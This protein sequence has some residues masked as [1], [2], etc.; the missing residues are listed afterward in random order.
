MDANKAS[1]VEKKYLR[2]PEIERAAREVVGERP[3]SAELAGDPLAH[4]FPDDLSF[5]NMLPSMAQ[6]GA[7]QVPGQP[8]P[9]MELAGVFD[10]PLVYKT[11]FYTLTELGAKPEQARGIVRIFRFYPPDDYV[12]LDE[13]LKDA[14]L[15]PGV[16]RLVVKSWR[17]AS[18]DSDAATDT[19]DSGVPSAADSE[20]NMNAVRKKL[21]KL[22]QELGIASP[23]DLNAAVED[24]EKLRLMYEVEEAKE[25]LKQLKTGGRPKDDSDENDTMEVLININGIPVKKIIKTKDYHIWEPVIMKPKNTGDDGE[26]MIEVTLDING[27]RAKKKIKIDDIGKWEKYI[28][29]DTEPGGDEYTTV[30]LNFGGQPI[31]RKIK[32]SML[33]LYA[34]YIVKPGDRERG[35][36]SAEI[37]ELRKQVAQ[38]ADMLA[39]ERNEKARER[40]AEKYERQF[41]ALRQEISQL[42]SKPQTYDDPVQKRIDEMEKQFQAQ[43][44]D[45]YMQQM[46]NLQQ[47][48]ES[49][50]QEMQRLRDQL[51]NISNF[52]YAIEQQQRFAQLARKQGYVDAREARRLSEE[53]IEMEDRLNMVKRKDEAQARVL[54]IAA[55][56]LEK[57]GDLK[58]AFINNGG[59]DLLIDMLK[60]ITTSRE[61]QEAAMYRPTVE[62][63]RRKAEQLVR[64]EAEQYTPQ[65]EQPVEQPAPS[66]STEEGK[67]KEK[68]RDGESGLEVA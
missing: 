12:A 44:D 15:S 4:E 47:T 48:L 54:N 31:E 68:P 17:L 49:Y 29:R 56:K 38:M 62:D 41:E 33:H 42:R 64:A 7:Q 61:E 27:V 16:R 57:T 28:V 60:K 37:E 39:Q 58:N 32:T 9:A 1:D 30:L 45:V 26:D 10:V 19:S 67:R 53:D 22:K 6:F 51:S 36:S 2:K 46:T 66:G 18:Q 43:K 21:N 20:E 65:P 11:L 50:R 5:A 34:P 40:E 3:A 8:A 23:G 55:N 14:G 63:L 13:I 25:R 35:Q 59:A 24:L 52:D